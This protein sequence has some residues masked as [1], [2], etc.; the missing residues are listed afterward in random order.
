MVLF[1]FAHPYFIVFLPFAILTVFYLVISYW[2]GIFGKDFDYKKHSEVI[3]RYTPQLTVPSFRPSVDI[4]YPICGEDP[5]V[6]KNALGYIIEAAI[7]YGDKA[8]VFML[9]DSK[10]GSGKRIFSELEGRLSDRRYTYLRRENPGQDKKSGNLR[11]AFSQTNGEFIA[12]F[13]ADFCPS[14]DFLFETVA[15]MKCDD[16]ISIVQTPQFFRVED[17]ETWVGKGASFVQELFYRLINVNRDTYNG[18]ICVGTNALYRRRDLDPFGGTALVPYSEDVRTGFNCLKL[19]RRIKYLPINLAKG[20]CPEN[21]PGFFLQQHRWALGSISLFFSKEFWKTKLTWGQRNCFMS[22]M[23]YYMATGIS[24]IATFIPVL[25]LLT[26]KPDLIHWYNLLFAVPSLIFGTFYQAIWSKAKWG[27]YAMKSRNVSYHAHLF[28]LV[29]YLTNSVT[30]WQPTGN[31]TK[32]K[33]Y[34]RFQN[35]IFI[36]LFINILIVSLVLFRIGQG[37]EWLQFVPTILLTGLDFYI[38]GSILKE[39]I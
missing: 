17:H 31:V 13:D 12:I 15:W 35:F 33:L 37:Y 38:K 18:A 6:I 10:D 14:K 2:V 32:T 28:A 25:M 21:L 29:E 30:P 22:G 8:R 24:L 27:F 34:S 1:T 19:G 3:G 5:A 16:N 36:S 23:F 9:D 39:Q 4:Y 20:L 7:A 26:F 11:N